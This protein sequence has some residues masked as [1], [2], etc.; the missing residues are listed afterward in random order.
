MEFTVV[1]DVH[2]FSKEVLE[3]ILPILAFVSTYNTYSL[4]R[5]KC[6]NFYL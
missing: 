6:H 1:M 3:N 4:D 2:A 5:Q